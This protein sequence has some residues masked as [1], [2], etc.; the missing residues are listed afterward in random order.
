VVKF[1]TW[2]MALT[3]I[4]D[5]CYSHANGSCYPLL[6]TPRFIYT[7][8]KVFF[9]LNK[10]NVLIVSTF[11]L[12]PLNQSELG[13]SVNINIVPYKSKLPVWIDLL[14]RLFSLECTYIY[15]NCYMI[16]NYPLKCHPLNL[17]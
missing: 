1:E 11:Y 6:A 14:K 8:P 15:I 5:R 16:L 10:K 4:V 2:M 13:L 17:K 3:R 7:I 9:F 12:L